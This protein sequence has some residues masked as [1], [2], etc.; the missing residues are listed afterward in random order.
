[1][2]PVDLLRIVRRIAMDTR[3]VGI[4]VVEVAPAYDHADT[5][6]NNG[7]R[8]IWEALS[9]MAKRRVDGLPIGIPR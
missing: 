2:A 4:D 7:H 6:A 9:G 8:V 5:T 1:M 3:L